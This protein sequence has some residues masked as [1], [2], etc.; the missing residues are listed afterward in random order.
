MQCEH[1]RATRSARY[2]PSGPDGEF[3]EALVIDE[4]LHPDDP[5]VRIVEVM[6]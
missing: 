6:S 4:R 5:A 2:R 3:I 1:S